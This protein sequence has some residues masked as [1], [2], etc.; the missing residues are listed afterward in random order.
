MRQHQAKRCV[1]VK[2]LRF[3]FTESIACSGVTHLTQ[4]HIARQRAHVAGT[5]N[6]THHAFCLVHEKFAVL[7]RDNSRRIL[8]PVLK[9]Q[10]AVV[11]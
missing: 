8:T 1:D 7:L 10:Q 6:V 5:K 2:R 4:A 9:Q 11:N 3:V